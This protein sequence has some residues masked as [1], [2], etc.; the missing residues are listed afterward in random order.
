MKGPHQNDKNDSDDNL[1]LHAEDDLDVDKHVHTL[2]KQS[3]ATGQKEREASASETLLQELANQL[4]DDEA[5]GDK[6]KTELAQIAQ[7]RWGKTL[8]AAKIKFFAEK[9]KM[10][11]KLHSN[12]GN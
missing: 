2:T 1:S 5:T 12:K 4:D 10:P 6:I 9:Y 8:A 3:K 11:W 7:K